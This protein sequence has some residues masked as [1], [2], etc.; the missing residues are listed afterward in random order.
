VDVLK[1]RNIIVCGHYGCGAVRGALELPAAAGGFV[2]HWV[3]DIRVTRDRHAPALRRLPTQ[4]ARWDRLC[5]LNVVNQVFNVTLAPIV[6]AAWARGQPVAVH[7]LVY[8]LADGLLHEVCSPM[9]CP[10][11]MDSAAAHSEAAAGAGDVSDALLGEAFSTHRWFEAACE[12]KQKAGEP[13][14]C[15]GGGADAPKAA[16]A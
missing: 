14:E 1:V 5:E 8:S 6:Q 9:T 13:C 4:T 11:D 3:S 10:A 16:D 15:P 7:G 2:A 12:G